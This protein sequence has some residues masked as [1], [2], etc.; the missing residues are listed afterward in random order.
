[1]FDISVIITAHREG[2]LAGA[3]IRS[4]EK[5]INYVTDSMN[6]KVE[7][8]IVLDRSDASTKNMFQQ[9]FGDKAIIITTDEGDPGQARNRGVEVS[10]GTFI[11]F[12]D[13]DDLWST[14]WLFAAWQLA[15]IEPDTIFHS[16]FNLTFGAEHSIWWHI[17]SEG[18]FFDIKYLKWGNFWDAM[19]FGDR[20][21]YERYPFKANNLQL[22][23]GHEDWHWN[24]L[25][26][27]EGVRHMP[28]ERTIHFK[29]RR[30]GSQM[31]KVSKSDS[32]VWPLA[33]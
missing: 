13:G 12:L 18:P 1:M 20:T 5:A 19:S 17:D 9:N 4:A 7:T 28:V 32:V 15:K 6:L 24:G 2:V 31:E 25:T 23:F 10:S 14:N 30:R 29:R 11:S 22:G 3:T 33:P 16:Q 8:I 27:S 21:I 26:I